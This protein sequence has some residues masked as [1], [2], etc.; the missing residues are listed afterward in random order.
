M[1]K[2]LSSIFL[3]E[4]GEAVTLILIDALEGAI[5]HNGERPEAGSPRYAHELDL[6]GLR[7]RAAGKYPYLVFYVEGE[8]E[9][10]V[11][12]VLHGAQ[13]IAGWMQAPRE[14]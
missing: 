11:W 6:I 1:W 5:R 4:S 14:D 9:I 12:R 2:R 13:Y 8:I 3:A 7:F 10:V